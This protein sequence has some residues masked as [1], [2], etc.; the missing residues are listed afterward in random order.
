MYLIRVKF[1]QRPHYYPSNCYWEKGN[2]LVFPVKDKK[3][4]TYRKIYKFAQ[5]QDN[6]GQKPYFIRK[7]NE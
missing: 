4:S 7:K 3:L 1:F 5:S 6:S 2:I